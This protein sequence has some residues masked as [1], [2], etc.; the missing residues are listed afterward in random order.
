MLNHVD[1]YKILGWKFSYSSQNTMKQ[2]LQAPKKICIAA[3]S[4]PYVDGIVLYYALKYFG[5]ND[6]N[7]YVSSYC[8]T[9]YLH[10]SCIS[11]PSS[12]YWSSVFSTIISN[13]LVELSIIF[14][15]KSSITSLYS[16]SLWIYLSY[17]SESLFF[18]SSVYSLSTLY[19]A[20]IS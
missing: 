1:I 16:Y 4:T 6:P 9:P 18:K 13:G 3:H 8:I 17:L 11:I 14:Y 19:S 20:I 15:F 12:K 7:I 10:K 2:F 5:I